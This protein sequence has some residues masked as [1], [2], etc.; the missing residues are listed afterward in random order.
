MWPLRR[1]DQPKLQAVV[2]KP[3][4]N[5]HDLSDAAFERRIN[6]LQK[7]YE[8]GGMNFI[9]ARAKALFVADFER[10]VDKTFNKIKKDSMDE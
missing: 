10:K 6:E 2:E 5:K 8:A 7:E 9:N 4:I 1:K 3:Q